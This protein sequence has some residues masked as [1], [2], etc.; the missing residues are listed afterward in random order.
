MQFLSVTLN[1]REMA[2]LLYSSL[3]EWVEALTLQFITP[4]DHHAFQKMC[5]KG[6]SS[7]SSKNMHMIWYWELWIKL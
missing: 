4:Q 1:A 5:C 6:F 3:T 2:E 7:R